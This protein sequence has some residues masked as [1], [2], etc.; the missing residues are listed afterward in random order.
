MMRQATILIVALFAVAAAQRDATAHE[1]GFDAALVQARC[2][3]PVRLL[4]TIGGKR[5][6]EIMCRGTPPRTIV[7]ICS[8]RSGCSSMTPGEPDEQ[9]EAEYR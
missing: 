3:G 6:Y 9:D 8:D 2:I 1:R 7:L 4:E 5:L